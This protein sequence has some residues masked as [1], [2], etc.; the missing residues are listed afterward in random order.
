MAEQGI[1]RILPL[2]SS[3]ELSGFNIG[4]PELLPKNS[5]SS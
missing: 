2:L 3:P 4:E 1:S 5:L